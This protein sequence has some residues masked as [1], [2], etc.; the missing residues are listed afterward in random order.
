MLARNTSPEEKP[1]GARKA[2]TA[3]LFIMIALQFQK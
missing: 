2:Q 3:S 1:T